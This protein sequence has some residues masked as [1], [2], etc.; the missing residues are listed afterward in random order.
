MK[1]AAA[2]NTYVKVG[3][4]FGAYCIVVPDKQDLAKAKLNN[5]YERIETSPAC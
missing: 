1:L 4:K 5:S 3:D 2:G